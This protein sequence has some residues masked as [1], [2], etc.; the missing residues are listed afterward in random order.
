VE[1]VLAAEAEDGLGHDERLVADGA[2]RLLLD[3]VP[4]HLCS[5]RVS[6]VQ[7]LHVT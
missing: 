1:D 3:V 5:S 4:A 2:R 7:N 6:L